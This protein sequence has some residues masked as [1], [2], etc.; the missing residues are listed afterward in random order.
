M[1]TFGG[2]RAV[3]S[4]VFHTSIGGNS[5]TEVASQDMYDVLLILDSSGSIGT[6]EFIK[7]KQFMTVSFLLI[8]S[9]FRLAQ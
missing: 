8:L 3:I 9:L 5:R 4:S 6:D 2:N 7:A 1:N